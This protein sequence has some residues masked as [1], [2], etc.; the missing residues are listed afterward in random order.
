MTVRRY[1]ALLLAFTILFSV[2]PAAGQFSVNVDATVGLDGPTRALIEGLPQALHDQII[3]SLQ[4]ALPLLD[5]S[6]QKYVAQVNQIL[7]TQINHAQCAA[8]GV[9]AEIDRR[10]HLPGART[11]GPIEIFD[12][13]TKGELDRLGRY[14]DATFYGKVYGDIFYDATVTLCEME[15]ANGNANVVPD[16]NMYRKL[17]VLWLRLSGTC[18][19]P[20]NCVAKQVQVTRDLIKGSDQRDVASVGAA[21]RLDAVT[22]S[23]P[24]NPWP[25]QSFSPKPYEET[26]TKLLGI[27]DETNLAKVARKGRASALIA[28]ARQSLDAVDARITTAQT[29]LTPKPTFPC[30]HYVDD[31]MVSAAHAQAD[32]MTVLIA[33]VNKDLKDALEL[34]ANQKSS[35]EQIQH[36]L[37]PRLDAYSGIR[38]AHK[39]LT[40]PDP[41]CTLH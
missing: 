1:I 38:S 18:S 24:E 36:D 2:S 34:D 28:D 7:D 13:D 31:G 8:T 21:A 19:S 27:Q 14:D 5:Q 26:L 15:I 16:E 12:T 37:Q 39:Y 17:N 22:N 20:R 29:I 3:K 33:Q 6:V 35:A 40:G 30:S 10:I 23:L 4:D 25:W 41:N 32:A 9:V 11:K